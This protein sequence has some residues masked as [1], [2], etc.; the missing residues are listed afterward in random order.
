[1]SRSHKA[2]LNYYFSVY[3]VDLKKRCVGTSSFF[4]S[5]WQL[6]SSRPTKKTM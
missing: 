3:M 2:S 5:C 4:S 6:R 1:M